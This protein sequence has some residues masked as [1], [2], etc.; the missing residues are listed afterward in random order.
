MQ[1]LWLR[2]DDNWSGINIDLCQSLIRSMEARVKAVVRA[3]GAHT[4]FSNDGKKK[5]SNN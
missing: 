5:Y 4:K 3:I 2:L 1:E